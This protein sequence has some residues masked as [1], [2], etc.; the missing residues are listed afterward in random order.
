[1]KKQFYIGVVAYMNGDEA[2]ITSHVHAGKDRNEA[3]GKTISKFLKDR[4]NTPIETAD[5]IEV[6]RY[7]LLEVLEEVSFSELELKVLV[8]E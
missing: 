8:G 5:V 2:V 3:L 6:N 1:M 4:P 7:D